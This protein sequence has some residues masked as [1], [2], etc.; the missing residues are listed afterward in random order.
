LTLSDLCIWVSTQGHCVQ[1]HGSKTVTR[2]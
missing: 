1:T 2:T